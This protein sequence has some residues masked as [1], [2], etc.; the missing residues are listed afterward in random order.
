MVLRLNSENGFVVQQS[1]D[2]MEYD[3]HIKE[4]EEWMSWW[5]EMEDLLDYQSQ[6]ID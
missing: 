2:V 6:C 4:W 5:E 1:S 3:N